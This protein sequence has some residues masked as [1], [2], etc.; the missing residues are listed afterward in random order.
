MDL[1]TLGALLVVALGLIGADTIMHSGSINVEVTP[2]PQIPG[3]VIDQATLEAEFDNQLFQIAKIPS[4]VS[5]PDI[6]TSQDQGLGMTIAQAVNAASIAYAL[7]TEFGYAPNQVRLALYLEHGELRG[8][9]SG[10]DRHVGTFRQV[11]VPYKDETLLPFVRRCALWS[12]SQIAPYSTALYLLQKHSTDQNFTDVF[13]LIDYAKSELPPTP[14]SF[15][16]SVLDNLR[17]LALLFENKPSDAQDA[18]DLAITEDPS[19]PVAE[20]N[21]AFADLQLDKYEKGVERMQSLISDRPPANKILLMTAYM[22][23]AAAEMGLH[24]L[25]EADRLLALATATYPDSATAFGLWADL[26]ALQGDQKGADR[27]AHQAQLNSATFENYAELAA[28]YFRLSWRD[29]E[30]VNL[31]KFSNPSVVSF[32]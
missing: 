32:H 26:K 10:V 2:P 13:A 4:V 28:L 25:P 24:N 1:T 6:R 20:I 23:W 8:Q 18:F 15:D 16:K 5:P 21:A 11:F 14:V 3:E 12:A 9:I 19:N 31:N 30:E 7:Q 17:G 27:Y 22:T 29:N